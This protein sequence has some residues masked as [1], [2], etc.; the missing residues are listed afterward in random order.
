MYD[1]TVDEVLSAIR[2]RRMALPA[3]LFL[4]GHRPLAFV[5]GQ[6]LLILQ[7]LAGLLGAD[8]LG[9]WGELLSQPD[10]PSALAQRLE[11]LLEEDCLPTREQET[12]L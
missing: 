9:A 7:P 5:F 3:I 8:G 11:D 1:E 2:Q 12:G 10:G 6:M 4:D